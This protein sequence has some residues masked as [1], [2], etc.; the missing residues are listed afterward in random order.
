MNKKRFM[1]IRMCIY[2][3][4]IILTVLVAV[5]KIK[6]SC[7]FQDNFGLTCPACGLTRATTSLVSLDF[8]GA[9]SYNLF[10]TVVLIPLVV[11]LVA[12]D[13]FVFVKRFIMKKKSISFIEIIF[14]ERSME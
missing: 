10:Y 6:T 8:K 13:I 14:G 4:S 11:G 2:I 5:G 12:N 9:L 3:V 1:I 7:F